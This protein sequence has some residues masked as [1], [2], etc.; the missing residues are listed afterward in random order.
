MFLKDAFLPILPVEKVTSKKVKL[1]KEFEEEVAGHDVLEVRKPSVPVEV[2]KPAQD[3]IV[4][5]DSSIRIDSVSFVFVTLICLSVCFLIG[6][7]VWMVF[8]H[9]RQ[10]EI[11]TLLRTKISA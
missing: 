11:L 6:L 9:I 10:Q 2:T 1:T 7:V 8:I 5:S 3:V 4:P